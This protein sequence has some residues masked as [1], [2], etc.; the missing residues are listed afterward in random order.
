[1]N[2]FVIANGLP[3]LYA[4]GCAF[5]VRWDDKGFTVGEKVDVAFSPYPLLSD[6]E[7]MAKCA[8]LDS[9]GADQEKKSDQTDKSVDDMTVE[10]LK[11]CAAAHDISLEGAKLKAEIIEAIKTAEV[12]D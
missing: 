9:I 8:L 10:E 11:E 6:K 12:V 4:E 3:Y 5:A 1:M 2:R 7:V